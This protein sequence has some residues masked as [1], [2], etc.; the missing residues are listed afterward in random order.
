MSSIQLLSLSQTH[1][2]SSSLS[3]FLFVLLSIAP[4]LLLSLPPSLPHPS[5]YPSIHPSLLNLLSSLHLIFP[6]PSLHLSLFFLVATLYPPLSLCSFLCNLLSLASLLLTISNFRTF[7]T[8]YP[9]PRS[10]RGKNYFTYAWGYNL[11][12]PLRFVRWSEDGE[13]SQGRVGG[14][15]RFLHWT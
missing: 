15:K 5:I 12:G 13:G 14:S 9:R 4:S 8:T 6:S 1:T 7:D 10:L 3:L 11:R 2:S